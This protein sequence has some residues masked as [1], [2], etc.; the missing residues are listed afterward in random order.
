MNIHRKVIQLTIIDVLRATESQD[1][2]VDP[3][4]IRWPGPQGHPK[5]LKLYL[6]THPRRQSVNRRVEKPGQ[7]LHCW[8]VQEIH[9]SVHP[10]A[11]ATT[12]QKY[13]LKQT[14][15][16]GNMVSICSFYCH[17]TLSWNELVSDQHCTLIRQS[18]CLLVGSS[19]F[20]LSNFTRRLF[21][22]PS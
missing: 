17:K 22:L 18:F 6:D 1:H 20:L 15:S 9:L 16:T 11:S 5:F 21:L 3:S 10:I 12:T 13:S 4:K 7:G 8:V 2:I 19:F 14:L